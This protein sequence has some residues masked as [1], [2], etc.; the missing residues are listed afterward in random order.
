MEKVPFPVQLEPPVKVQVP[1]T[2][3]SLNVPVVDEVPF[4]VPVRPFG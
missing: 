2:R 4:E 1:T 3:P